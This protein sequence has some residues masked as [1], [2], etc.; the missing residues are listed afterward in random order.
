[1]S[2]KIGKWLCVGGCL[3]GKWHEQAAKLMADPHNNPLRDETYEP[4]SLLNPITNKD[5]TFFLY[6]DLNKDKIE[7]AIKDALKSQSE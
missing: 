1:M 6:K 4:R 7:F 3:H 2:N 5:E